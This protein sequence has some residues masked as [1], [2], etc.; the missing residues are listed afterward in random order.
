MSTV[1]VD[2]LSVTMTPATAPGKPENF[3]VTPGERGALSATITFNA[4]SK[5]ING[6]ALQS[7]DCCVVERDG[8]EIARVT[9][10]T[11]GKA[12][13]VSDTEGVSQNTHTYKV[14]SIAGGV[15]GDFDTQS[16]Y[17]GL[18]APGPVRNLRATEDL[19]DPGTVCSRG[20]RPTRASTAVIST[21]Q[22]CFMKYP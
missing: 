15:E 22:A 8:T 4:P 20:T 18:D 9:D 21:P 14:Y 11:P 13:S 19:S 17:I 2:D 3:L 1:Y 12:I 7:L 6:S 10:V 5:A 16:K